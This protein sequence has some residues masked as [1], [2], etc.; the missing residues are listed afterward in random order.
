MKDNSYGSRNPK[1][2]KVIT[3]KLSFKQRHKITDIHHHAF[4]PLCL[5]IKLY[6]S[7]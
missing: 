2:S 7:L 5:D 3:M 1:N 4:I 6:L